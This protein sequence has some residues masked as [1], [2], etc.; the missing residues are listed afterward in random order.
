M[1]SKGRKNANKNRNRGNGY[2][3]PS[4]S[5]NAPEAQAA[6]GGGL[7]DS[8]FKPRATADT[9]MPRISSALWRGVIT[10][11]TTPALV[12]TPLF[13]LLVIWLV[14]V[15]L[16]YQ[17]PFAPFTNA[18]A[19]PP[20][21]TSF[22]APIATTLFGLQG[23]LIAL[24]GFVA[25]RAVIQAVI[26]A[27][28]VDVLETG[29][30][31]V[32]CLPR[33]ARALPTTVAVG[34]ACMGLLTVVAIIGPLF[35]AGLGLLVQVGALVLGVYLFAFAPVIAVAEGRRMPDAMGRSI[36]AGRMPGAGN[37]A[38]AVVY[39]LPA[40]ALAVFPGKPGNL[41]GVNPSAWA[42]GLVLGATLLHVVVQAA[43]TFRYL[44][45]ADEVPAPARRP[46]RSRTRKR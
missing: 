24:F 11:A 6:R 38:F 3:A 36:R 33:A 22:D 14:V 10:V 21:G 12:L 23:G 40:I 41:L 19:V 7:L 20:V 25:L 35:G 31:S 8:L 15:A 13:L 46:A 42:W 45:V 26:V 39:V 16:G 44:S 37:L 34:I 4:T 17:G 2:R 32:W 5:S 9:S 27:M 29:R 18:L 43:L 1:T 28:C 30:T